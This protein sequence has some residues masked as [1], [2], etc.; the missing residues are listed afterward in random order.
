M[1]SSKKNKNKNNSMNNILDSSSIQEPLR[2]LNLNPMKEVSKS[3]ESVINPN[4]DLMKAV[5]KS[6]ESVINPNLDPMK[7]ISKS[8]EPL[9]NPN[10]NPMKEVSKSFEPLISPNLNLMKAVSKNF[11]SIISPNLNPM[12]EISK[13]FESIINPNLNSMKMI[14]N[15]FELI[16]EPNLNS[17]QK[18]R[19]NLEKMTKSYNS[20]ELQISLNELSKTINLYNGLEVDF[21]DE[22]EIDC[23]Q[24]VDNDEIASYINEVSDILQ[25]D[26]ISVIERIEKIIKD[27]CILYKNAEQFCSAHPITYDIAKKGLGIILGKFIPVLLII[28]HVMPYLL[29]NLRENSYDKISSISHSI[30]EN[31]SLDN[32]SFNKSIKKE[33]SKELSTTKEADKN[34][35]LNTYRFVNCESLNVRTSKTMK[36]ASIYKLPQGAIVRIISKQKNWTKI[37]YK[38]E[39]ETVIIIGW[40]NTRYISRFK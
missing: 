4:L 10:L 28:L 39:D 12:K 35:L 11:E 27:I 7:A 2:S 24:V 13:N 20:S 9:I 1:K 38:N 37:E 18:I 29:I 19:K 16:I 17:M 31:Y 15:S 36:S 34:Y 5:S 40:V 25:D 14:P 6:F 30:I 33:V 23:S 32:K 3:F 8:F 26:S 21:K 22:V